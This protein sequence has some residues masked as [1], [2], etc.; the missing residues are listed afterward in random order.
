MQP[1]LLEGTIV[2]GGVVTGDVRVVTDPHDAIKVLPGEIMVVP[3]SHPEF[4][5]GVMQ[6]AGLVCEQGG[7]ISHICT[8]ALEIGIPCVTE[9]NDAVCALRDQP[10]V[11]LDGDTGTV[12]AA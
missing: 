6:A 11:T 9:V 2:S 1:K 3:C 4:A 8:V 10:R 5:V 12:Y 7:I